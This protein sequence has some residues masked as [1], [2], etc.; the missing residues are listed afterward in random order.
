MLWTVGELH[1]LPIRMPERFPELAKVATT[2][3]RWLKRHPC[4]YTNKLADNEFGY[5]FEGSVKNYDTPV[6]AFECGLAAL[7]SGQYFVSDADN[8]IVIDK[9]CRNLRLR[10]VNCLCS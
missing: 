9:V 8:G 3:S 5:F 4:V 10:G 2:F 7:R 6:Y 1:F